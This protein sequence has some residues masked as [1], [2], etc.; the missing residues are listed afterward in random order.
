MKRE[1]ES[2]LAAVKT[3]TKKKWLSL[4]LWAVCSPDTTPESR[5]ALRPVPRLHSAPGVRVLE[6]AAPVARGV[7]AS[8]GSAVP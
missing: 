1:A 5:A 3:A 6:S 7:A 8:R 2:T 4:L